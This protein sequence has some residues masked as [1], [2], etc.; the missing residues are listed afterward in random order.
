M[1]NFNFLTLF[2]NK[3]KYLLEESF[4]SAMHEDSRSRIGLMR[5]ATSR[6]LLLDHLMT[7]WADYGRGGSRRV[8][9]LPSLFRWSE[10]PP[11]WSE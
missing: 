7:E 10:L 8:Q 6:R 2:I 11:L 9:T 5:W 1:R 3:L 4:I